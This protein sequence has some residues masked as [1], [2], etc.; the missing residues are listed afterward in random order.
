MCSRTLAG[1]CSIIRN[2]GGGLDAFGNH[3]HRSDDVREFAPLP[4]FDAHHTIAAEV[5]R[6]GQD[7]VAHAGEAGKS[8]APC[9]AGTCQ[10]SHLCQPARNQ[11][12]GGV[13]PEPQSFHRAGGDG[14]DVL[15]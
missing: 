5:A 11:R 15:H 3:A 4:E 14:N 2:G 12:G 7:Q 10:A 13:V 9:P 8:F 6:A 1:W